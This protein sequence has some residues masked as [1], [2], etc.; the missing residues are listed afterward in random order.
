MLPVN[1]S[2]L[3]KLSYYFMLVQVLEM[4]KPQLCRTVGITV[5]REHIVIVLLF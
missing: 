5:F 2:A 1:E 3:M 4:F